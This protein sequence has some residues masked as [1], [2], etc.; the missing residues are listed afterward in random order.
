MKAY[1]LVKIQAGDSPEVIRNIRSLKGIDRANLTFGPYDAL[2]VVNAPGIVDI[3]RLVHFELLSI[4]GVLE[5][6]TCI[7]ID[8]DPS[9]IL[10]GSHN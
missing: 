7:A 2:A 10:E 1:V 4:P 3:G 6:T 5:T 8:E 9:E